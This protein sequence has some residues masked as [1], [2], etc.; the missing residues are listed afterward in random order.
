QVRQIS[1]NV[2]LRFLPLRGGRKGHHTKYARAHSGGDGLDRAALAG[3]VPSLEDD[4]DLLALVPHP[5]LKLD[6]LYV[7]LAQ[8]ALVVL[9]L[10]T[11]RFLPV[12]FARVDVELRLIILPL[13]V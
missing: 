5:F 11:A 4:A 1:L 10:E 7:Q 13:P 9:A 8:A 12:C 2:H 6:Q 3:A